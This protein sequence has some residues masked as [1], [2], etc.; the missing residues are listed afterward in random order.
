M[1][2]KRKRNVK[3]EE[4]EEVEDVEIKQEKE[5]E[6]KKGKPVVKKEEDEAPKKKGRVGKK[7]VRIEAR[8]DFL[9]GQA[10]ELDSLVFS[11][12]DKAKVNNEERNL[13]NSCTIGKVM[14]SMLTRV[15]ISLSLLCYSIIS[16]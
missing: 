5:E 16:N 4:E 6:K 13:I 9:E 12:K 10:T 7:K 11:V 15:N 2:N 3:E 1:S 14:Y 8:S